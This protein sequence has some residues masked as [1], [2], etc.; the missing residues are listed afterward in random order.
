MEQHS[1]AGQLSILKRLME[2]PP[3]GINPIWDIQVLVA[4]NEKSAVSRKEVNALMQ[5]WLNY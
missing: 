2:F 5:G 1:P 3:A 4:V